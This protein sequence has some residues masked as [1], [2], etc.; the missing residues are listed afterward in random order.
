MRL[1]NIHRS[2]DRANCRA[3]DHPQRRWR[4]C[5]LQVRSS[6]AP[7]KRKCEIHSRDLAYM[8]KRK[9]L[10]PA[11]SAIRD[12]MNLLNLIPD[13]LISSLPLTEFE[14]RS[15]QRLAAGLRRAKLFLRC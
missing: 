9:S 7:G 2:A 15:V 6:H 10:E 13:L 11:R 12:L 3:R 1:A 4:Q 8:D 5:H 14:A